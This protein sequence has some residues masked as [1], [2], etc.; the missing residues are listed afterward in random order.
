MM[1]Q[2]GLVGLLS[3]IVMACSAESLPTAAPTDMPV[4]ASPAVQPS[5]TPLPTETEPTV[6]ALEAENISTFDELGIVV[7]FDYPDGF[8][9]GIATA[10]IDVYEPQ[11]PFDLP[12]PQHAQILFTGYASDAMPMTANGIRLF[13]VED[14]DA[15][16]AGVIESLDA[17]REE[18]ADHLSDF[19]RF[20]GAGMLIDAKLVP[21]AFQNGSGYRYLFTKS[22]DV[23][24]VRSTALTYMYQGVTGDEKYFVS[25]IMTVQASFLAGFIDQSL[26]TAEEF[27]AYYQTVNERVNT[28]SPDEFE[29]TLAALDEL[30]ASLVVVPK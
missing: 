10:V 12:Y 16:E 19:P 18:Q 11:A 22:Y 7:G 30:V 5:A 14:I 6:P 25:V 2:L 9:Q 1:K 20:A 3:L 23:A 8:T 27:E 21:L 28:A 29:P 15:L 17:V 4:S 24:P 13:R 26:T